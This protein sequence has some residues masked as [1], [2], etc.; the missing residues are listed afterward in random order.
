MK[1][2]KKIL[3]AGGGVAGASLAIRLAGSGFKVT[4]VERDKFPRHKLC[5][6]FVSPECLSHFEDLGIS[7][8]INAAGGDMIHET[9]FYS[10]DGRF[11]SVPSSWF[12]NGKNGALSISRYEMDMAMLETAR[13]L[14]VNVVEN[15]RCF[16]IRREGNWIRSVYVKDGNEREREISADLM[17]DATGRSRILNRLAVEKK[18][19][20]QNRNG[21]RYVA[22]K[23]H[24]ENIGMKP[25]RCEIYF[26]RGGYGGLSHIENG[27]AN[28]CFIVDAEIAKACQGDADEI[29][30]KVIFKNPRALKTLGSAERIFDWL[31]VSI[32]SF[33]RNDSPE[34]E[35]LI[36]IGDA[37]AFIDP[38]TGS[39]MLMALESSELLARIIG[40]KYKSGGAESVR[41]VKERYET[42]HAR[43]IKRRL[44]ICSLFHR[45]SF[46]P[47]LASFVITAGNMSRRILR[48]VAVMTR[49]QE[50]AGS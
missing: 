49:P 48:T 37:A 42:D 35:N 44:L 24:F 8:K 23:T 47:K 20:K 36:N 3:I 38:F 2:R 17:I 10:E 21:A 32:Q 12:F 39:G 15:A 16:K 22:F 1:N 50:N 14:G 40:E 41:S 7:E 33:G 30:R 46:S 28:H 45:F 11:L 13:G 25:G 9:R 6:E 27:R 34:A 19:P 5:G 4:L 43:L 29:L 31:A 18:R 26:F